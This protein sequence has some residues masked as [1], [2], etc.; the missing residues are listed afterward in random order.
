MQPD[1]VLTTTH[2]QTHPPK[3]FKVY[4]LFVHDTARLSDRR[5]ALNSIYISVN[6]VLLG[7]VAILAQLG[8]I[9]SLG[10]LAVE[11]F[12]AFAGFFIAGQ[13]TRM[14]KKYQSLLHFRF[15]ALIEVEALLGIDETLKIYTR[16]EGEKLFG[17]SEL[18]LQL[19][20]IFRLFYLVGTF[21]LVIISVAHQLGA[22]DA[23]H[24]FITMLLKQW[25]LPL[26]HA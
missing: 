26:P 18:E 22:L 14:I 24:T 5:Q 16:E 12:V 8:G 9:S 17:F 19:P 23:L 3:P 2:V 7:A 13:W 11:A 4:E 21:L 1:S 25:G 10:F 15:S 6:S 20:R